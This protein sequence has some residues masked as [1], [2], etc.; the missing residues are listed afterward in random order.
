M[1]NVSNLSKITENI[2]FDVKMMHQAFFSCFTSFRMCIGRGR[3]CLYLFRFFPAMKKTLCQLLIR[4][5]FNHKKTVLKTNSVC[6]SLNHS[7]IDY[8]RYIEYFP[9]LP[10]DIQ[11]KDS[12][13]HFV[14]FA[15]R[16]FIHTQTVYGHTTKQMQTAQTQ[17]T[18]NNAHF[19]R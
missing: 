3:N 15:V 7:K 5:N 10:F 1:K 18:E 4:L 19:S 13:S 11:Q 8:W 2:S 6:W 14:L 12:R 16:S 9:S 17:T